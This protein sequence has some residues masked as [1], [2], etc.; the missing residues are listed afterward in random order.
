MARI[1]T[2]KIGLKSFCWENDKNQ[3]K[4]TCL[5]E[6]KKAENVMKRETKFNLQN[7]K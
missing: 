1:G 5:E 3:V 4:I 6:G 7:Q 2:K